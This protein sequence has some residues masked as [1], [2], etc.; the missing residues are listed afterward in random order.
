[1]VQFYRYY[2]VEHKCLTSAY[3]IIFRL[4][5]RSFSLWCKQILLPP[6]THPN[7]CRCRHLT[8]TAPTPHTSTVANADV[9]ANV[10]ISVCCFLFAFVVLQN[11][12]SVHL[13][14]RASIIVRISHI[15]SECSMAATL[16]STHYTCFSIHGRGTTS[17]TRNFAATQYCTIWFFIFYS[18]FS[19]T[20]CSVR[21]FS[22]FATELMLLLPWPGTA[23]AAATAT[24]T[25]IAVWYITKSIKYIPIGTLY[26]LLLRLPACLYVCARAQQI[27][28]VKIWCIVSF[29]CE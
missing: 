2:R 4:S 19:F 29:T 1:M 9:D 21:E 3:F 26:V 11:E 28:P 15:Y 23:V 24:T 5:L 25:V 13:Y 17:S 22:P 8:Q 10:A 18:Y 16:H 14:I 27:H 12:N 7:Q 20:F 6:H